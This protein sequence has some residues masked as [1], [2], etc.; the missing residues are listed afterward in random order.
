MSNT[1]TPEPAP[2]PNTGKP[3]W[4]LVIADI[5]ERDRV[6]RAKYGTPL[7]ANNGR[8][9][10]VDAY[11]EA[12]DLCVYLRQNIEEEVADRRELEALRMVH[13]E[14]CELIGEA[15]ATGTIPIANVEALRSLL[16]RASIKQGKV[17]HL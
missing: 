1:N 14:A 6:G 11:Q 2:T 9:A 12:L 16:W 4:E 13:Q 10:L 7:Q 5:Q 17:G 3:I 15:D 8:N